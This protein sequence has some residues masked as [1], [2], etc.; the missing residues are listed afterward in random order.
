M[1][2]GLALIALRALGEAAA[3]VEDALAAQW[4][5]TGFLANAHLMGLALY[6][7]A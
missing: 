4:Q 5:R 1:A 7:I 6:S 2:L 3:D